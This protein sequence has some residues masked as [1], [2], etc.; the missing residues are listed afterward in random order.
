MAANYFDTDFN[1]AVP[2]DS[3]AVKDGASH[4]RDI[5]DRIKRFMGVAFNLGDGTLQADVIPTSAL[6]TP[7]VS[8]GVAQ[9]ATSG[10]IYS[11]VSVNSQGQIVGADDPAVITRISDNT[12]DGVKL[13]DASVDTAKLID[14]NVGL[15]KI[16]QG[17]ATDGQAL[18]W[19]NTGGVWTPTTVSQHVFLDPLQQLGV[20][21]GS[22]ARTHVMTS[23]MPAS[24]DGEASAV[25]LNVQFSISTGAGTS[26]WRGA[27]SASPATW[28]WEGSGNMSYSLGAITAGSY[29]QPLAGGDTF[30]SNAIMSPNMSCTVFVVGFIK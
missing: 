9:P 25:I 2:A 28:I 15:A 4:I 19:D 11:R 8:T 21:V 13:L 23:F 10:T 14:G 26:T 17:G 1:D 3:D 27:T 22:A 30:Y 7:T 24:L 29:I 5:K 6:K 20:Y 18:A 12:L 16:A